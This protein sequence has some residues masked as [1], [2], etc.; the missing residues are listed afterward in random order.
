MN[1]ANFH[2]NRKADEV[3]VTLLNKTLADTLAGKLPFPEVI[4]ILGEAGVKAYRVDLRGRK[5]TYD[6]AGGE[7]HSMAM[8]FKSRPI[9]D[10]FSGEQ[11]VAAIRES[12]AGKLAYPDFIA[13]VMDA[14][15]S[16][17]MVDF[18]GRSATYFGLAG[19]QHVENFPP[20]R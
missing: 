18:E 5:V 8:D 13:R 2:W 7:V 14:G 19:G 11:V 6:M 9:G 12:Q 4:R 20:K 10:A 3:I 15:T 16:G 1:S 17:Y